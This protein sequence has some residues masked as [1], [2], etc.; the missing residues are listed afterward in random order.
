M[1]GN[2]GIKELK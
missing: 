1:D 2:N